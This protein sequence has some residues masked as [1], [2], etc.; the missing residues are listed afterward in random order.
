METPVSLEDFS[1]ARGLIVERIAMKIDCMM[2]VRKGKFG[3]E[4][5]M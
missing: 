3:M 5:I 1:D 4:G 2:L